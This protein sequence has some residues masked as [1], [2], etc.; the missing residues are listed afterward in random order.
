[1]THELHDRGDARRADARCE[2][3][4][5]PRIARDVCV[6]GHAAIDCPGPRASPRR[7]IDPRKHDVSSAPRFDRGTAH[8]RIRRTTLRNRNRAAVRHAFPLIRSTDDP[9]CKP[10][11]D[12]DRRPRISPRAEPVQTQAPARTRAAQGA[13]IR[14]RAHRERKGSGDTRALATPPAKNRH[15]QALRHRKRKAPQI[16]EL[17]GLVPPFLA[18][19]ESA[20][21]V[22]NGIHANPNTIQ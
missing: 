10:P 19:T 6:L 3:A 16:R 20:K 17:A 2:V 4:F 15:R 22:S 7:A 21:S 14:D 11:F 12:D 13:R 18:E 9:A 8:R 1:M 5:I